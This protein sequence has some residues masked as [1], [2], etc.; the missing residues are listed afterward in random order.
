M[1]SVDADLTLFIMDKG[2][3]L[4]DR[5]GV[6]IGDI[7]RQ[8]VGGTVN[9]AGSSPMGG[10]GVDGAMYGARGPAISSCVPTG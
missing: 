6:V 2:Q 7:T 8:H 1:T 3:F 5:L 10:G 9:A 4:G